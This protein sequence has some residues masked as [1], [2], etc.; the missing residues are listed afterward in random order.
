[1]KNLLLTTILL[2]FIASTS[3]SQDT[4]KANKTN[5]KPKVTYQVGSAKIAV[6]E[7]PGE[8]GIR[9]N[10]KVERVYRNAGKWMTSNY[11]NEK[12]LLELKAVID[13]AI[14]GE[15]VK[16]TSSELKKEE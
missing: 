3:Y 1:M 5:N 4:I 15:D 13:K 2:L 16:G 12:E 7:N 6:W 9:K 8:Q 14:A 10:F 11:F